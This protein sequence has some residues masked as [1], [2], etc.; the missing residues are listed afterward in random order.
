MPGDLFA[1]STLH[2]LEKSLSWHN[3][4]QEIIAGNLANLE[5]PNYTRKEVDFKGVLKGYLQGT[6]IKLAATQ[7]QHLQGSGLAAALVRDSDD[8]VDLDREMVSL[9]TNQLEYQASVTMLIKKLG[10]LKTVIEGDNQ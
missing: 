10:Q 6:G 8:P 3:R 9:S 7:A 5:T 4:G 2:L 1:D